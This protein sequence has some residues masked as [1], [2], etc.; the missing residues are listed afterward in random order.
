MLEINSSIISCISFF[1]SDIGNNGELPKLYCTNLPDN[2][3]ANDL[4]RLF[5]SFGQVIDSVIL[6]DYY[7]FVTYK[8]FAEAERALIALNGFTWK[9]RRL[10]VE[11]SRASGRK[12]QQTPPSSTPPRLSS[13]SCM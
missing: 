3:Q 8:T 11:W 5:S 1:L 13:Y 10:I 12:Q 4:Q 6:W 2:C 7:A 9:D